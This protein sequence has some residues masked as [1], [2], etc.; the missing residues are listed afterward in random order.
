MFSA[1]AI[2][3]IFANTGALVRE[4]FFQ[5]RK[6][7]SAS[8]E[9]SHAEIVQPD[10]VSEISNPTDD[11]PSKSKKSHTGIFSTLFRKKTSKKN[12]D[13]DILEAFGPE[14]QHVRSVSE[15]AASQSAMER[16]E[17]LEREQRLHEKARLLFGKYYPQ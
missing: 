7:I 17:Q 1:D 3:V 14:G 16:Q 9:E 12:L 5:K 13:A 10:S 11:S 2:R 6:A 4:K 15:G 8:P